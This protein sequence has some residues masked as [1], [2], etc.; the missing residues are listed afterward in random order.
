MVCCTCVSEFFLCPLGFQPSTH[1]CT[2]QKDYL[3]LAAYSFLANRASDFKMRCRCWQMSVL[4]HSYIFF[5]TCVAFQY[6]A[7]RYRLF[8]VGYSQA[9]AQRAAKETCPWCPSGVGVVSL[10]THT[11]KEE[12]G[13][14]WLWSLHPLPCKL[15]GCMM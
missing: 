14:R 3:C 11:G 2:L 5:I 7:T 6:L 9:W 10:R 15:L 4:R 12:K 1:N 8:K 13:M